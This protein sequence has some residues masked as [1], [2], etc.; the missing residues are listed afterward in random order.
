MFSVLLGMYLGVEL[1]GHMVTLCLTFW[2]T[3]KLFFQNDRTILCSH[4]QCMQFQF[5][6]VPVNICY[7][8]FLLI[9][10]WLWSFLGGSVIKNLPDNAGSVGSIP[11]LGRSSGKGH[12]S[13]LQY[14]CWRILWSEEPGGLQ[15]MGSQRVGHNWTTK[16]SEYF[17]QF[18]LSVFV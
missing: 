14:S 8:L 11:G 5:L 13:P 2:R 3:E 17:L 15:S 4:Q 18:N 6:H 16:H 12:G 7:C 1:L 9:I 10:Y